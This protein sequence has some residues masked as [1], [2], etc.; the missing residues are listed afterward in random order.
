MGEREVAK[1]NALK[2][3]KSINTVEDL[4]EKKGEVLD[5]I[6]DIFKFGIQ[7]LQ[8]FFEG[9]LSNEDK[10]NEIA[11]FQDENYFFDKE[12]EAE[13]D[14]IANLQGVEE[15]FESFAEEMQMR[16][17]PHMEEFAMQMAKLM[18]GFMGDMM[19]GLMEGMDDMMEPLIESEP[20]DD[21]RERSKE[22]YLLYEVQ[23]L[24]GLKEYKDDI[25]ESIFEQL[26]YDLGEL[27]DIK[28]IDFPLDEVEDRL[29]EIEKD[30]K[31]IESELEIEFRRIEAIPDVSEHAKE[32]KEEITTRM[33]PISQEINE[34]L[35]EFKE[36]NDPV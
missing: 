31:L 5:L 8:S 21:D 18:E 26:N 6:D 34:L 17:Q 15:Y 14:R 4:K 1:E 24:E 10:Q 20:V 30:Y 28:A 32:V 29:K 2:L 35:K 9:S 25:I 36:K 19:G 3:L 27:K 12:I 11:K 13:L 16:I 22:L 7:S 33:K 23:S